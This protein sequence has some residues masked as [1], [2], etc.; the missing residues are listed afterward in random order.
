MTTIVL[1]T[2]NAHKVSELQSLFVAAGLDVSCVAMRDVCGP[3]EIDETGLT[4]EENAYIKAMTIHRLTGLPV[5]ADDSGLEVDILDGAPG[6]RSARYA[7]PDA[8]DERNR[9]ALRRA[10]TDR[11]T[12]TS[13][14]RFRCVLCYVDAYRTLF[15][16]G[17]CEGAVH[18]EERGEH[19]FG[20]D[21]MFVPAEHDRSFGEM[22]ASEKALL[23]HRGAA[24][25]DLAR[26]LS[27]LMRD[28]GHSTIDDALPRPD[29]LIMASVYAVIGN[30]DMLRSTIRHF[31]RDGDD[32]LVLHEALLQSY[33]FAGFP[34]ALEALA[35]VDEECRAILGEQRWPA[36]EPFDGDLFRRRG[37]EL[38]RRVY[39]SV[40]DRMMERLGAITPDLSSWMIVEGYGKT[41]S[42]PAL[43]IVE[44]ELC[45]V[46]MLAALG[47]EN[48][49]RSHVRGAFLVGATSDHLRACAH[50]VVESCGR[51]AGDAVLRNILLQEGSL[52]SNG[53]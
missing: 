6:V 18:A 40:Y 10:L 15:G 4:F 20:Y 46:G 50:V 43:G 5:V 34:V 30:D 7:G 11:G 44:R 52:A 22:D 3:V 2:N 53:G 42:R 36:A 17:S 49:L 31:V 47:R 28:A 21:A 13:T 1:A 45:I 33:L 26:H 39:G 35:I 25:T 9:E 16:V 24:T 23:S 29:A 38:C 12:S 19:G 37:E 51:V 14:A 41:L 32:A 27:A 8:T 48:Q